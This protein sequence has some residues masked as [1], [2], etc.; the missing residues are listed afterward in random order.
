MR[1]L[2]VGLFMVAG[3][4]AAT[5]DPAPDRCDTAMQTYAACDDLAE[6]GCQ[7]ARTELAA[8]D[9]GSRCEGISMRFCRL[10]HPGESACE[11]EPDP[12][13]NP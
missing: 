10:A 12:Q 11:A 9:L 8:C 5:P 2:L 4:T 7:D 6:A 3:C 13:C 1:A